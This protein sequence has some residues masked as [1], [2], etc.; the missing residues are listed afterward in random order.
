MQLDEPNVLIPLAA[1]YNTRGVAGFTNAFSNAWDQRKVNSIYEVARNAMTGKT[2]LYLAKRPGTADVGST[3][4]TTGQVAHL[5]EMMPGSTDISATNFWVF[6]VNGNDVRASSTTTTTVIMTAAGYAPVYVDKAFINSADTLIVQA[7]GAS[8]TQ[9][10]FFSTAIG[11]FTEIVDADFTGLQHKG[12]MEFMDGYAFVLDHRSRV[13]NSDLNSLANW[14]ATNFITKQIQQD[15]PTGLAK[16]GQQIIAFGRTT[17][18]VFVNAGNATGS[19]LQS[20]PQLFHRIGLINPDFAGRRHY[21]TVIGKKLYW[22]SGHPSGLYVYDGSSAAKVS[23]DFIGKIL[24]ENGIYGVARVDFAAGREAVAVLLDTPAATT[25]RWLMYFPD[26]NEWF[27]WNS[28]VIMPM[29]STRAGGVCLGVGTNQHKLYTF[30]VSDKWQDAGTNYDMVHEFKLPR[31]GNHR[32]RMLMC[33]V[34]GDTAKSASSLS[35]QFSDDDW[36]TVQ[37]ARTIDQTQVAK[38]NIYRCGSYTDR[39]V[40]LIQSG[41][42]ESRLEAFVARVE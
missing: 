18:E 41:N 38:K 15:E 33:G 9:R 3:Y 11:T 8:T 35:V 31:K 34:I 14:T 12:K 40:R 10:V 32:K 7:R 2:T 39:S 20:V 22:A 5:W 29:I 16:L 4:G 36:L 24:D 13:Y 37:A 1:S 23:T 27:T 19:P 25:Q 28:T 42:V 30:G 6:S 26:W 21:S 17:F